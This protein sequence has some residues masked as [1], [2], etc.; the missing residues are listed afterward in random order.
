MKRKPV[1]RSLGALFLFDGI[2]AFLSPVEYP[3]KLEFGAPMIDDML[4]YFSENPKL[5]RR[6]AIAEI[7]IGVWLTLS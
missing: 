7:A 1:R 2:S 5:T 6:L 3:R 4:D